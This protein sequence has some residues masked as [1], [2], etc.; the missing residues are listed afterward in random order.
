MATT[1]KNRVPIESKVS[2]RA[3]LCEARNLEWVGWLLTIYG[4]EM[5]SIK[6]LCKGC[7]V[8]TPYGV[9]R[10]ETASHDVIGRGEQRI[11]A[12]MRG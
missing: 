2:K 5:Y 6:V 11:G 10:C 7:I 9:K 1:R 12:V 4:V 8:F 3:C